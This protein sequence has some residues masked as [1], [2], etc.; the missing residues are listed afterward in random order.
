[1]ALMQHWGVAT[2]LVDFTMS[3]YIA[4]FFALNDFFTLPPDES[5]ERIAA[6]WAVNHVTRKGIAATVI[7]EGRPPGEKVWHPTSLG[8]PK[9]FK[10][11]FFSDN[12]LCFVA[13]VQPFRLNERYSM[14]QGSLPLSFKYQAR[15]RANSGSAGCPAQAFAVFGR[16]FTR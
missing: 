4:L 16:T 2:R 5:T 11:T 10:E 9:L 13:P 6:I 3:P 15:I 7:N 12:P 14:Q 1:M 8:D